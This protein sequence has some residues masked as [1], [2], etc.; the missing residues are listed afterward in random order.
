VIVAAWI[1]GCERRISWRPLAGSRWQ[2]GCAAKPPPAGPPARTASDRRFRVALV[3]GSRVPDQPARL[4][5]YDARTGLGLHEWPLPAPATSVD[6]AGGIAVLSSANGVYALRVRDGRFSMVGVKRPGDRPQI[7]HAGLVFQ[8]DQYKRRSSRHA[9]LK[10]LPMATVTHTLRPFGPLRVP[11]RIGNFSLDGRSVIFVKKDPAGECDRIGLWTIPWHYSTNLMAEEPIC[12]K[13]HEAGGITGL[14]LAGQYIEILTTY[15]KV[16]TLISNSFVRCIE[17][18]VTRKR[19]A[20]GEIRG[21]AGDGSTLAYAVAA[22]SGSVRIGRLDGQRP[23][24]AAALS[25]ALRVS[26]DH[27][28]IAVLRAHGTVVLLKDE[29]VLRTISAPGARAIGL[30]NDKLTV[31]TR[32]TLD[33][34]AVGDGLLLHS[35]HLPARTAPTVDVHYG[36]AVIVAGNRVIAIRLATGE[37]RVLM[38]APAQVRAQLD[39]IGAVYTYNTA[40]G[41]VLG[42]IPFAAI[43]H[44]FAA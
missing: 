10:F 29:G 39:D 15:G 24:G 19:L 5:V 3:P 33:V 8:D 18:V 40:R 36:F 23:A 27:D 30:R 31:L 25:S 32:R 7:A 22:K 20:A 42:V 35:W 37:Q 44:A 13:R 2:S 11:F 16:Q 43:D 9:L 14:A 28:R 4:A 12:P 34:Y 38:V 17:K 41:G 1:K 6:V 26:V 21:L